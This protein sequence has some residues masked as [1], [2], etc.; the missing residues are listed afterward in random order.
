MAVADLTDA[1]TGDV[2]TVSTSTMD[3]SDTTSSDDEDDDDDNE[4]WEMIVGFLVVIV[5]GL[6]MS[7]VTF[8]CRICVS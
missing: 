3:T 8:F 4:Y 2:D 6:I 5:F 1:T 7:A